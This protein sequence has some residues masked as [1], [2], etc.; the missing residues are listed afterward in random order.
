MIQNEVHDS[1]LSL[2]D[3]YI[4]S[5]REICRWSHSAHGGPAAIQTMSFCETPLLAGQEE[6][7]KPYN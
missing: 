4:A 6:Q 3:N 5:I 7:K 1:K 2:S